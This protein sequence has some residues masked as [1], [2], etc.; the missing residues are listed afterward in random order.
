[1][2]YFCMKLSGIPRVNTFTIT[3]DEEKT[4]IQYMHKEYV[5]DLL[6]NINPK[7]DIYTYKIP[8]NKLN[9]LTKL[10]NLWNQYEIC[11]EQLE[12]F[13]SLAK[14]KFKI[15]ILEYKHIEKKKIGILE[16]IEKI[17]KIEKY[18]Y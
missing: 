13:E 5:I 18:K 8:I 4:L 11:K 12:M 1:M 6:K 2:L 3:L 7:N 16:K 17:E 9:V 15:E 10:T 14:D